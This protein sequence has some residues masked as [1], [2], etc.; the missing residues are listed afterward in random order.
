MMSQE[1]ELLGVDLSEDFPATHEAW[2]GKPRIIACLESLKK[3][4][5][6]VARAS[7]RVAA[8]HSIL[9]GSRKH[10][11]FHIPAR[12]VRRGQVWGWEPR[13][14][15]RLLYL[16]ASGVKNL[17]VSRLLV[18]CGYVAEQAALALEQLNI[19]DEEKLLW[20]MIED[21]ARGRA[22]YLAALLRP[23]LFAYPVMPYAPAV[24]QAVKEVTSHLPAKVGWR[25]RCLGMEIA[26]A[27]TGE[28]SAFVN[29][30]FEL[31]WKR[32]VEET[33]P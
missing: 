30:A 31:V 22:L 21:D 24:A 20:K 26:Q 3:L 4:S 12:M 29:P 18:K 14:L 2:W 28:S 16:V 27:F 13:L 9:H 25:L 19:E 23:I 33:E 1:K 8:A 15:E 17:A 7:V 5:P 11:L 32:L 10:Y 6:L